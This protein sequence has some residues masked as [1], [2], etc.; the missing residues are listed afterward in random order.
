MLY[1]SVKGH[2]YTIL[3]IRE[4]QDLTHFT[5][6]P[7]NPVGVGI[8]RVI[9]NLL[10]KNSRELVV[11]GVSLRCMNCSAVSPHEPLVNIFQKRKRNPP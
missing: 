8:I 11:H 10:S 1:V 4:T 5:L 7:I 6:N 3:V 2:V 9:L